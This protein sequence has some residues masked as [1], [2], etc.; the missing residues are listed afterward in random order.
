MYKPAQSPFAYF[1]T[2][3]FL[4]VFPF[5]CLPLGR[6]IVSKQS[7]W[8]NIFMD[9]R[10]ILMSSRRKRLGC[11]TKNNLPWFSASFPLKRYKKNNE[12]SDMWDCV[13]FW[14]RASLRRNIPTCHL[15]YVN[16]FICWFRGDAAVVFPPFHWMWQRKKRVSVW[17]SSLCSPHS[18]SLW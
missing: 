16:D 6:A 4:P 3:F 9:N 11:H 10:G 17:A 7:Y 1:L 15:L 13:G 8:I 12:E 14:F 18:V 5:H 2:A